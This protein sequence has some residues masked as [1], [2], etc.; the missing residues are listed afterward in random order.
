LL[1]QH[2][3]VMPN[4]IKKRVEHS[5]RE[6]NWGPIQASQQPFTRIELE[7]PEFVEVSHGR[8]HRGFQKNSGK[9]SCRLKTFIG[10]PSIFHHAQVR[11]TPRL[12]ITKQKTHKKK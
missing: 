1:V 10:P 4:H 2:G 5:R 6:R 12:R 9:F 8:L 7:L 11:F 3:V